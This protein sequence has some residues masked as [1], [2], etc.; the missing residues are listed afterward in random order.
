MKTP[1]FA[2][3]A[4]L[5]LSACSTPIA[6][7]GPNDAALAASIADRPFA[8][9]DGSFVARSDGRLT[10][11]FDGDTL[12]GTWAIKDGQWCRALTA[13]ERFVVPEQCQPIRVT[14]STLSLTRPNGRVVTYTF[15]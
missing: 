5:A 11:S 13:P 15:Q 7:D 1:A 9:S 2:V 10:G 12:E 14:A 4:L 8:N 6:G 3:A